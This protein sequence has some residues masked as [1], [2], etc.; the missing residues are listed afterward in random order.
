MSDMTIDGHMFELEV[1]L[2]RPRHTSQELIRVDS[3]DTYDDLQINTACES[4]R[5]L[6]IRRLGKTNYAL[7]VC[8]TISPRKSV[9][10][11]RAVHHKGLTC[12]A[13]WSATD[14]RKTG[15]CKGTA[16]TLQC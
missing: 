13:R 11:P 4:A 6:D 9:K 1:Q 2:V 5:N 12:I 8:D 3:G 16:P 10:L 7:I 14:A 15:T